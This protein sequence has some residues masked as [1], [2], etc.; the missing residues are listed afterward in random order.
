MLPKEYENNIQQCKSNIG[1]LP[2]TEIKYHLLLLVETIKPKNNDVNRKILVQ[3]LKFVDALSKV[4]NKESSEARQG[5]NSYLDIIRRYQHLIHT[6]K[7]GDVSTQI[8]D[9]LLNIGGGLL[10]FFAGT[11]GGLIG[12]FAGLARGIFNLNNPFTSF[13][14]GVLTGACLGSTIG[15]RL[16]QKLFQNPIIRQLRLCLEGIQ[17][18]L[19]ALQSETKSFADYQ[20]EA[21]A[22]L[23]QDY[24]ADDE[25]A[26][27]KF[28]ER[29][30]ILYEINTF[31]AQFVSPTLE[32][33]LGHH[34]FIK[35]NIKDNTPLVIEFSNG[36]ADFKRAV[37][38]KDERCVSGETILN[39]LALHKQLQVTHACT[40]K[41]IVTKMKAGE[42]DCFTY[43]NKILIGTSQK[44]SSVKRID[45]KENW[46]GRNVGFFVQNL[47][48]LSPEVF[49]EEKAITLG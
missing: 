36:K 9:Q 29:Q 46:I 4:M 10:A 18:C 47:S 30:D 38:Q 13:T 25:E 24:F 43:V 6:A 49:S 34:A 42:N 44:P 26:L 41:Y 5:R 22:E 33:F 23:L 14:I 35:I 19:N 45:G 3:T 48:A 11:L 37:T 8:I 31:Y 7:I 39:M 20:E 15:F 1:N 40:T 17:E 2:A 16:P 27:N 12:G 28:L 21:K 32:R